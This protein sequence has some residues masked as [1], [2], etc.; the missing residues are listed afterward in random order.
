MLTADTLGELKAAVGEGAWRDAREDLSAYTVDFRRLY[1]GV[2]PLVLLPSSVDQVSRV[3][4]ICNR[5]RVG[6]VPQGGN[7][8]Y[9]GGAT[10]D[11]SG[12]QIVLS[13]RR[14]NRVRQIDAANH[15]LIVEAGCTLAETHAAARSTMLRRTETPKGF[16]RK[17]E[18]DRILRE[19]P[20]V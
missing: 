15:S 14:L 6:I 12:S 13:M 16:V 18:S 1:R 2:T 7:T 4:A 20:N 5:E 19:A 8:G 9:C 11:E 17:N 3:L 10:P